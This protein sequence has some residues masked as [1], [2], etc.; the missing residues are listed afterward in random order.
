MSAYA[1]AGPAVIVD[2][3][4]SGALYAPAFREAGVPSV[5]LV[6]APAPPDVYAA[7]YRPED[8]SE[9]IVASD[10]LSTAIARLRALRPRCVLAGCES[11]VE[12]ADLVA[13][14][15]VPEV[16]NAPETASARRHKGDMARAVA[17]A[18]LP[19]IEQICTDDPDEVEAW[20]E[21]SGL[22][23]RDLVIKPPKSAST[24]GV[25][26]VARGEGWHDVFTSMLG[27]RNRLGLLNDR[28]VV[29]EYCE[30]TE[31]VVDTASHAGVHSVSDICR[32]HKVD[33]GG[34]MAVYESMS[35]MSP[36][37][38]AYADL[39][40]Y[41]FGVLDAVGMRFGAA[42]IEL[43]LTQRG[44]RLIE[45]GA[46][47]HGGGHPHF[48]RVATGESQLDRVVRR[49]VSDEPMPASYQLRQ[50]VRVLFLMARRAGR[51][52]NASVLDEVK[53]LPSH[54][55]SRIAIRDGDR[56][57]IT[58]DLFG[59]LDLGFVVLA[60]PEL[61]R[62]D[63]DAQRMRELEQQVVLVPEASPRRS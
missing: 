27:Q 19:I 39:V 11:G 33:N 42:H 36:L 16:A 24:D 5:A 18:G 54:H 31:Y 58:K 41:A 51:V 21:R 32:Y 1:P 2:P 46:R 7:S 6:T 8:F 43:M 22:R 34:H 52:R 13:P 49:F 20:I 10:G 55:F 3:Y 9:V 37:F 57:A 23:G 28:L 15:V 40:G 38:P 63:A 48:C 35:W 62:V 47:P 12:L 45:I 53:N 17:Q 50:H 59:S 4:S 61:A 29:Q 60:H 14:Q 25:T 56:L 44:P 30:G 26:R